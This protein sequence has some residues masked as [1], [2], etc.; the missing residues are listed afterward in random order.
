MKQKE[1]K[2]A[3]IQKSVPV[4]EK[5]EPKKQVAFGSPEAVSSKADPE[6]PELIPVAPSKIITEQQ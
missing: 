6:S 5:P 4:V 2:P 3:S 1:V